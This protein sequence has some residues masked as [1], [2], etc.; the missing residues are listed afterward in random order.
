MRPLDRGS[1]FYRRLPL[2]REQILQLRH[3]Q[4]D[5]HQNKADR[6]APSSR[7]VVPQSSGAGR[8]ALLVLTR[9]CTFFSGR[10]GE[11]NF[12]GKLFFQLVLRSWLSLIARLVCLS[13]SLA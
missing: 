7:Q 9:I 4:G 13:L 8:H 1:T 5:A 3:R 2:P 6:L 12:V 11:G 10:F